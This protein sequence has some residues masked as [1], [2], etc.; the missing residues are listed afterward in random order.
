MNIDASGITIE[1]LQDILQEVEENLQ[2]IYGADFYIKP[3]GVIDSIFTSAGFLETDMQEQ[4]AFLA[5][6]FD[7]ESAEGVWQDALYERIGVKRISAQSTTFTKKILGTAG[8]SGVIGDITIRSNLTQEEFTNK[9]DYTLDNNGEAV[10]TFECVVTGATNVI[11][12]ET[13]TIVE[14]PQQITDLATSANNNIDLGRNRE[15]DGEFR[16]RFR[17]AK[18]IDA[19]GTRKANIANLL[20][21]VDNANYL[22]IIDKKNDATFAAGTLEIIAKHNT[23]DEI[24]A[25]AI[26]N[27]V[28]DGID[29]LGNT[30]VNVTDESGQ[31]V[32]ITFYKA[33]EPEILITL[34]IK[35]KTGFYAA[36]VNP[37]V[38]NAIVN[39]VNT[40][41]FGLGSLIFA[42]E[43][44][45][46]VLAV[47]GV[48]A[49]TSIQIKKS[50]DADY[51]DS[52][53]LTRFEIPDFSQ[54]NITVTEV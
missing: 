12:N 33:D 50:T 6:Q 40:R 24:F 3:E 49:V 14:A 35:L 18:G 41:G 4:L 7:P 1:T 17:N 42:T 44:V 15:T 47:D 23:T 22:D 39:Y 16:V 43:F 2:S 19:K 46:P 11:A 13:F 8:F 32:P 36:A 5:K 28:A 48:D 51:T 25:N 20:Q 26:F 54:E 21:Y 9:T 27:T 38:V 52:I 29:L 34:T 53:T 10:I 45:V 31:T 37:N 30:T